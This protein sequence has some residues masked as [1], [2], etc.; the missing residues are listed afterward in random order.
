VQELL[1]ACPGVGVVVFSDSSAQAAA[2]C[3]LAAGARGLVPKEVAPE[4][5]VHAVRVVAAGGWFVQGPAGATLFEGLRCLARSG[6]LDGPVPKLTPREREYLQLMVS[7]LT[8]SEIA[9]SLHLAT[10]TVKR[11]LR[12]LYQ[13]LGA[14]NRAQAVARAVVLGLL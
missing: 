1:W 9:R 11:Q 6:P 5:L 8:D 2:P 7:G 4:V 13:Q 10:P 3:L 12:K 14:R